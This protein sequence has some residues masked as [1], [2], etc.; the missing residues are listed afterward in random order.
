MK[1]SLKAALLSALV[2]PGFGHFFLKKPIQGLLLAVLATLCLYFLLTS[3]YD[4]AQ[5]LSLQI[6]QGQIAMDLGSINQALSQQALQRESSSMNMPSF[7]FFA[8]W[9]IGIFDSYRIGTEQDKLD[10]S[11][12][13]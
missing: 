12:A 13:N 1:K 9:L 7:W 2:F 4:L 10:N 3:I 5:Q 6:Q 11:M 8:L